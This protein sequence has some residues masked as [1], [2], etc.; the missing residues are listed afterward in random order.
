MMIYFYHGLFIFLYLLALSSSQGSFFSVIEF[1]VSAS[2]SLY[3]SLET[4]YSHGLLGDDLDIFVFIQVIRPYVKDH[5]DDPP[6]N[7][8]SRFAGEGMQEM[9]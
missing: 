9:N 5:R 3:A 6:A 8:C 4:L 1:S 2:M 7:I